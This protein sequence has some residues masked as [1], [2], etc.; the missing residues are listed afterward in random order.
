MKRAVMI[1][2]V[3]LW[4]YGCGIAQ[5]PLKSGQSHP[6]ATPKPQMF[7]LE[8]DGQ[9]WS[10]D[11][12][13]FGYDGVDPTTLNRGEF[14]AWLK[15]IE[16]RVYRAPK[17]ARFVSRTIQPHQNGRKLDQ[18]KI[19]DWLDNIHEYVNQSL[20]VPYRTLYPTI[21]TEMLEQIKE[22]R[23]GRYSTLYNPNHTNRSHNI[24]L[25]AKA[26]DYHVVD[27]G[28]VFSFNQ[29]VGPRLVSRGYKPAPIIVRGEY[30]E[31]IGGGI[32]Q[33][34]STL[35]NAVDQAGLRI[36][37]RVSHSK[38]VTYVPIGRDATVSWGGPD[39]RF[40]NQLNQPVLIVAQAR[41]GRLTVSIYGPEEIRNQPHPVPEAPRQ[42]PESEKVSPTQ[43]QP[44]EKKSEYEEA[45]IPPSQ[46]PRSYGEGMES[47]SPGNATVAH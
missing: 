26:I 13:R 34:S 36:I 43:P 31:G 3:L 20:P 2:V 39:F 42:I 6:K 11:L 28:E 25:S 22:K 24:W 9:R 7:I 8:T 18:Q 44:L 5:E 47:T 21:T 32:C 4:V 35:F 19:D 46:L 33:T 14:H 16:E 41:Y 40:Q 38:E 15:P 23:I 1:A 12:R 45:P 27:V 29:V 37:Q 30:T 17:N 10:V